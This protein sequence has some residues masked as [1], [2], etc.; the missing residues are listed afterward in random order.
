MKTLSPTESRFLCH[1]WVSKDRNGE[2]GIPHWSRWSWARSTIKLHNEV[3][4][5]PWPYEQKEE[6]RMEMGRVEL[7]LGTQRR[8]ARLLERGAGLLGGTNPCIASAA[9]PPPTAARGHPRR[10]G[11]RQLAH[12]GRAKCLLVLFPVSNPQW[13]DS[14]EKNHEMA[15]GPGS[16]FSV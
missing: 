1:H 16:T 4:K 8:L 10:P 13:L 6:G 9:D 12:P 14:K 7:G 11:C 2:Y 3:L 5:R 15:S